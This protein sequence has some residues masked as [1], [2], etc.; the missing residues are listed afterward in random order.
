MTDGP[1]LI[2]PILAQ[3]AGPE[4][5]KRAQ[6]N[7]AEKLK[8]AKERAAEKAKPKLRGPNRLERRAKASKARSKLEANV[9]ELAIEQRDQLATYLTALVLREGRLR[10]SVDELNAACEAHALDM[11]FDEE[12]QCMIIAL[13]SGEGPG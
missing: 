13:A 3:H 2:P 4:E 5:V 8:L 9:R 1:R 11:H 10:I 7:A 6:E 12:G